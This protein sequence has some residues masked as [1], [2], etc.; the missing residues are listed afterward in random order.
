MAIIL[1]TLYFKVDVLILS[2]LRDKQEIAIYG[3]PS[4]IIE[5][6][7]IFPV[8]F[9]NSTLPTLSKAY[10]ESKEKTKELLRLSLLGM[11]S[12][13]LPMVVGGLVLARP[14]MSLVM[15]EAF[16]TGNVVGYYGSDLAFQLLLFPTLFAFVTHLFSYSLIAAG[17][18]AKLLKIN[19]V[20]V[21][22]NIVLN[23]IFIPKYGFIAAGITTVFSEMI[24]L[25]LTYLN[26]RK[27][28]QLIVETKKI[29]YLVFASLVMGLFVYLNQSL[30]H[31][32]PLVGFGAIVYGLLLIP[33]AR[34]N[35]MQ[36]RESREK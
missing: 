1:S 32:V 20:G 23:L 25:T 6:L 9:M 12:L 17:Q 11:V 3:F 36:F 15:N 13:S 10:K 24:V 18:Q 28:F 31:V 30:I 16:L 29:L 4:S 2:F 27:T 7:S 34:Q 35:L 33:I 8:Y 5:M 14:L 22:F 26:F 19:A 21:I